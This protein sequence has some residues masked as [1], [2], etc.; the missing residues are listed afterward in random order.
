MSCDNGLKYIKSASNSLFTCGEINNILE[1]SSD[2]KH[3]LKNFQTSYYIIKKNS[4]ISLVPF[5][6]IDKDGADLECIGVIPEFLPE[7]L[8][9]RS[10][11]ENYNLKYAY[12]AGSMAN[13]ISSVDMV[14]ALGKKGFLCSFGAG[15]VDI[16]KIEKAIID[17][18]RE[19]PNGPYCFNLIHNPY[20][21]YIEKQTIDLYLKHNITLIEAS[22]FINLSP[23]LVYYRVSGLSKDNQGN[24]VIKNKVIAK[25]SRPQIAKRFLEPPSQKFLK[26]L[27]NEGLITEEQA[28]LAAKLPV[29]DDITVESDSGGHTDNRPLLSIFTVIKDLKNE[30]QAK[31]NYDKEIRIGVGGGIS[32]PHSALA[33]FSIGADYV[34]TGS[35]NQACVEAGTSDFVRKLLATA[36]V[37]DMAMAPAA[38]M[39]E[40]GAKVQVLKKGTL[41]PLRAQKLY[42]IYTKY[43]SV[44]EIPID[45][46]EKI[47]NSFFQKTIDEVWQD[48]VDFFMKRDPDHIK[49]AQEDPKKKMALIFRWYLGLS[50]YWARVACDERKMDYQIWCGPSMGAFNDWV[51]GSELEKPENR[52]VGDIALRLMKGAAYLERLNSLKVLGVES[53][54]YYNFYEID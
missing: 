45:E 24:V 6:D 11:K 7:D 12:M 8:G 32:T 39:F 27:L 20:E 25:V 18:K 37:S 40:M 54:S 38:D 31:Y 51:K 29:A 9:S 52:F 44:D 41:Y 46:K 47:E 19:L 3:A 23:S 17:I 30:I 26:K 53:G 4:N 42:D 33:A 22:A 16:N 43:N 36:G 1:N 13:E 2:I 10:F 14:I 34:V 21:P 5:K 28:E 15:G 48:T 35:V 50:P 49:R